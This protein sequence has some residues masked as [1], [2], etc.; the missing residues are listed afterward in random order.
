MSDQH[1]S[2]LGRK[3]WH[4]CVPVC[5]SI[6]ASEITTLQ[7]PPP[8]YA[9][10]P[11]V[12]S[13]LTATENVINHFKD[14]APP[15]FSAHA[16][17][18]SVDSRPLKWQL[19]FGVLYDLYAQKK[20][21]WEVTVHFQ[22]YPTQQL[23]PWD[24]M[25]AVEAHFINNYKQAMYLLYGSTK[26][27]M[28]LPQQKQGLLWQGVLKN[29]YQLFHSIHADVLPANEPRRNIPVR[30]V[31][32]NEPM[33]QMPI[34]ASRQELLTIHDVLTYLV[35]DLDISTHEILVHGVTVDLEVS[36][37]GLYK[38]FVYPDGFL[39]ITLTRHQS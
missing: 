7:V 3:L 5:F 16:I 2:A 30:I 22:G 6:D 20:L 1:G 36:I 14:T 34:S 35:P 12:S 21:P 32:A 38:S 29:D 15:M 9:M 11:R 27:I 26:W 17:W 33:I 37:E 13:L 31:L 24:D 19:P 8:F 25:S 18:F 4:G 23:L 39:Y 28:N 10:V